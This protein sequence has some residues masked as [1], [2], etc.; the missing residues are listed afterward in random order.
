MR[1]L[2]FISVLLPLAASMS[3]TEEA[4]F[5]RDIRPVLDRLCFECHE[6]GLSK[7]DVPFLEAETA[8]EIGSMR[9]VWRS[10][11]AQLRN[12]TMPPPDEKT[13]PSPEERKRVADWVETYLRDSAMRMEP[14]AG[15]VTLRRLNRLEYD[16]TIQDMFGVDLRFAETMPME[17]GA[18]EGFNNNGESLFL[19]PMLL[20]RY[21]EAAQRVVDAALLSPPLSVKRTAAEFLPKRSGSTAGRL[22]PGDSLTVLVPVYVEDEYEVLI[23]GR[24]EPGESGRLALRVDGLVTNRFAPEA[25]SS[26]AFR[27]KIEL[28]LAHGVHALA[29][30][31][32]GGGEEPGFRGRI[33]RV[34]VESAPREAPSREAR[35]RHLRLAGV[36]LGAEPPDPAAQVRE[37]LAR[38]LPR[39]F[40]RPVSDAEID[41]FAALAERG[42]AR[43]D[44][45]E[46][47]LKLA[48][49]GVLVSP[50]FLYRVEREPAGEGRQPLS[51]FELVTRLSYFLGATTP[52]ERL[53]ALAR[54]GTLQREETLRAEVDRLLQGERLEVFAR[55]FVGQW[56]G[57]KDVGGRVAPTSNDVQ[58]FYTPQI[59]ADMRQEAVE[60][61]SHLVQ[62]NRSVLELVDSDYTFLTGRL[63]KFYELPGAGKV[64]RDRFRKWEFADRKR[65]GILGMGAVLAL[66]SHHKKTSPVLRGAWVF[67]T[68][69]GSPVPPPPA[70][71]PPLPSGRRNE[72]KLTDREKLAM[73]RD[74]A[75]CQACHQIIDPIGFGLQN[76][77]WVGRW[78]DRE[79]GRPVDA[80]GELPS[81]ESFTGP[82]ELKRVLVDRKRGLLVRNLTRKLLGYALGRSL[83]DEDDGTIE[84]IARAVEA[85]GYRAR[86]L[87]HEI[88]SSVPFREVQASNREARG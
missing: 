76:F 32:K 7:G 18:G 62:E 47:A 31:P 12:Y 39:L 43:G 73:H 72:K 46:E 49:R 74:H 6:P 87:L 71:V 38:L 79:Q 50:H 59:A 36:K 80:S 57:T 8:A 66:T 64:P 56:L 5:Q 40:R 16:R 75:S 48:L 19:P 60:Y 22:H 68:L 67:D 21:L 70:D 63:A 4:I 11:A 53:F 65:G 3:A 77:D 41:R 86:T 44:P 14:Y 45:Y 55:D 83:R 27:Q 42:L 29:L 34:S 35:E 26:G 61:F 37:Q 69:L 23:E 24:A 9:S 10:V 33:E 51:D 28:K 78:R 25:N 84:R 15:G 88:V 30:R 81:G 13:Q 52:D 2:I 82:G 1:W 58:K 20:E 17:G 85:D 54:E